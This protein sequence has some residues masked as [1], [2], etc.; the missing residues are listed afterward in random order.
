MSKIIGAKDQWR[1]QSELKIASITILL[2][3]SIIMWLSFNLE[4]E[5]V[6]RRQVLALARNRIS[7]SLFSYDDF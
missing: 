5:D 7:N 2:S 6:A 4:A 1:E 3:P